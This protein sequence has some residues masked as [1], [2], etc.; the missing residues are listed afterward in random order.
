MRKES[1]SVHFYYQNIVYDTDFLALYELDHPLMT[2][3]I[4]LEAD[5]FTFIDM[6]CLGQKLDIEGFSFNLSCS[7]RMNIPCNKLIAT[8]VYP[9]PFLT[10]LP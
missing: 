2:Q 1:N 5:A 4:Y 9:L 7:L 6:P 3:H 10:K 8:R